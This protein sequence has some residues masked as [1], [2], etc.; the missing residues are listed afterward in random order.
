MGSSPISRTMEGLHRGTPLR[1]VH[2]RHRLARTLVGRIKRA[3]V[4]TIKP[5]IKTGSKFMI[6]ELL[7]SFP[8][9]FV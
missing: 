7:P 8:W 4:R 1:E 3:W 6:K 2:Q 5:C 9:G